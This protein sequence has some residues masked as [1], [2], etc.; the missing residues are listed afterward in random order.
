MKKIFLT[1]KQKISQAN[2]YLLK[3]YYE[4]ESM[5]KYYKKMI[6]NVAKLMNATNS[7][8]DLDVDDMFNLEKRLANFTLNQEMRRRSSFKQMSLKELSQHI[9]FV[10][11]QNNRFLLINIY[12]LFNFSSI[13]PI[14]F[15]INCL[16]I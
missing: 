7:N 10:R 11:E 16:Q 6:T 13:G 4:D 3:E 2:W 8:L 12:F 14:T 15:Q 5:V 1:I 9:P